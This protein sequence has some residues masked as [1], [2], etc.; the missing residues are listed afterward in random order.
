MNLA[1]ARKE[2]L[3]IQTALR[4]ASGE[5]YTIIEVH[6]GLDL[7]VGPLRSDIHSKHGRFVVL[8]GLPDLPST[9]ADMK[10]LEG[11]GIAPMTQ[12]TSQAAMPPLPATYTAAATEPP[13]TGAPARCPPNVENPTDDDLLRFLDDPDF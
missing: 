7:G 6:G 12:A 11:F 13:P 8:G 2:A 5:I 1:A 9:D 3:N 10:G 4:Q